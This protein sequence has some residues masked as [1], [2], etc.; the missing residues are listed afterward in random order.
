MVNGTADVLVRF[1]RQKEKEF[2][3]Q[4]AHP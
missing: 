3:V 4:R 2:R 1:V